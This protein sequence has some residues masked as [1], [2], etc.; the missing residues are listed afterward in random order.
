MVF[1]VAGVQ[2]T[3][4]GSQGRDGGSN[5]VSTGHQG[6]NTSFQEQVNTI[7]SLLLNKS[8]CSMI[9]RPFISF[10]HLL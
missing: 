3:H 5:E 4:P 9:Y 10:L 1:L 7:Y 8:K 2:S 6:G